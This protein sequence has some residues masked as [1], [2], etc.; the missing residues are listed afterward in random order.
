[1]AIELVKKRNGKIVAFDQGKIERA[2]EKAYMAV[3]NFSDPEVTVSITNKVAAELNKNFPERIPGVED[4]QDLVEKNIAEHGDFDVARAY[5]LYRKEHAELREE[6][7][8]ELLSRIDKQ[9]IKVKKRDGSIVSFDIKE[10]EKAVY[11]CCRD[12]ICEDE[13]KEIIND[14]KLNV[15]DG[16]STSEINKAVVMAIKARIEKDSAYSLIA[17]RFL[18]ND[19]YKEVLGTN[20]FIKDFKETYKNNFEKAIREGVAAGRLDK[21]LLKFNFQKLSEAIDPDRDRLF[22]FMG[23]QTL[24]DRYFLRNSEQEILE[25]PQYFWM[26]VSM[27]LSLLEKNKNETAIDFYNTISQMYYMPSTPTLLHSGT[28]HPQM[29]SCYLTTVEDDLK[30]IF[31]C[32]GDN[33]QL[34]KWSGGIGNDWSNIRATNALVK[35]INTGSQGVIPFLKIVDATTASINRSGKRRGATCVYLE[36]WHF[37]IEDFLDLRKNTG[38]ER[39]RTHDINT[40]NWIPDLFIKRVISDGQWTL[41]SPNEVPDLH[42]I[43]GKKFEK[44]Y[45]KYEQ[46]ADQGQIKVWKKVRAKDLWRKMITMLFETGHPWITFKDPCNIRSPQDHVGVVHSS[47]LCTEITLNTSAEETAV[48]NLGS[49]NLARH[50][51]NGEINYGLLQKNVETALRMLDNVIDINF[52]PT[53]EA[54]TSNLRHRPVGL[55]IM[56]LQDALY[57]LDL[58]FDSE[59]AVDFSDRVME[60]ISYHAIMTSSAL[61]KEKGTYSSYKG[62]KWERGIFPIDTI[63]LLEEERGVPTGTRMNSRMDWT[64]AKEAVKKY[65]M[66]N[67]NCL[68]IAPTATIANITGCL[69]S[70]EP[71]YKNIYVKSNF[72]GEFTVVNQY[73]VEDLKKLNLWTSDILDKLK[74]YD[75]NVQKIIEIPADLRAKYKEVFEIDPVWIIKH[76]SYRG[77]WIDQSQSVNLFTRSES[78]PFISNIYLDAWKAGLKTTYYLRTL[79]ASAIE[80]S[81]IDINKVYDQSSAQMKEEKKEAYVFTD[82]ICESCQ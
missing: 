62:S 64:L 32:I 52:Y 33:A 69:P 82:G 26:R 35:S 3:N 21:G 72:S 29:S 49:I 28:T 74:Y 56:G 57:K 58:P 11:D 43:Y 22:A 2:L 54:E 16:I 38:D 78:G 6:K 47:N 48:C 68:A 34:S 70:I 8:R 53:I 20:E 42:H 44:Q 18:A 51:A 1:M 73:L 63:S 55:G 45:E 46:M 17:A 31:K 36:T 41:F 61:A 50:L 37:E 23:L 14:C 76:A 4:I 7:Q 67:S 80:K 81:T 66:R 25:A 27:G 77:K 40:A 75:G 9:E 13:I 65:G 60:F 12:T 79:G 10:I 39:R 59:A 71:I 24:Y 15:Y 5:I 30:H 19:L